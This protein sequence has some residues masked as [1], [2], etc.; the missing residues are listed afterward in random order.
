[1]LAGM[2]FLKSVFSWKAEN[3]Y[4]QNEIVMIVTTQDVRIWT[5]VNE[6]G[7]QLQGTLKV[8]SLFGRQLISITQGNK[9]LKYS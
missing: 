9:N 8:N 3:Q 4:W 2:N 5:K 7:T 6:D 1:M